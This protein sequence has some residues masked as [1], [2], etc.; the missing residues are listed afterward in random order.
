M[1][2]EK[3]ERVSELCSNFFKENFRLTQILGLMLAFFSCSAAILGEHCVIPLPHPS[4]RDVVSL[5]QYH[6]IQHVYRCY[7]LL[8][9]RP[10]RRTLSLSLFLS[11]Y[12]A[13][14]FILLYSR[15]DRKIVKILYLTLINLI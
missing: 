4:A 9:W 11:L 13:F 8:L 6:W 2:R 3:E 14:S 5:I 7:V 1:R 10:M 12:V 15:E